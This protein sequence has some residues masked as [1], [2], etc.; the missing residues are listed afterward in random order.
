MEHREHHQYAGH[1]IE[2][3]LLTFGPKRIRWIWRIDG[4]YVSKS[5]ATLESEELARSEALMYAQMM[6]AHLPERIAEGL[7]S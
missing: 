3:S 5:R 2:I 4:L 6:V 1:E 7:D